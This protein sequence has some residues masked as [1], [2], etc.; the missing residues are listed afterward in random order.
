MTAISLHRVVDSKDALYESTAMCMN[1]ASG[2]R[3]GFML[4]KLDW[5][6][7]LD[8]KYDAST[9]DREAF[10]PQPYGRHTIFPF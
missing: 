5:L 8:V 9:F 6:H 3:S 4:R 2:F 7:Y 10:A 1:G